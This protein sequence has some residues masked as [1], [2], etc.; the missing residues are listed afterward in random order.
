MPAPVIEAVAIP[1]KDRNDE[2]R[3]TIGEYFRGIDSEFARLNAAVAAHQKKAPK[4]GGTKA[5]VVT[6]RSAARVANIH[7]RGNFLDKG[8]QVTAGTLDV[9]PAIES[10]SRLPNR[11]D[12]A[13]WL[14]ADQHPLTA[15]VAVNRVWYRY[16]GRGL[17]AS[18]DDFGSQGEQPS[19]PELLDFLASELQ[20]NGWSLKYYIYII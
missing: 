19:H 16:F 14:V 9:L 3:K 10:K 17:V 2:Q 11:L 12:F 18:I 7:V 5:Q 8:P 4:S 15:R 6:E 20:E 1:V 13:Q